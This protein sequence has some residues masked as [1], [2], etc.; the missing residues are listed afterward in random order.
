MTATSVSRLARVPYRNIGDPE[1]LYELCD[2]V[3]AVGRDLSLPAV[4]RRIVQ[5]A[6]RL[7]DA[8][9]GALGVLDRSGTRLEQFL[10]IGVD[11]DTVRAIGRLPEGHGILG[12]LIVDPKPLRLA[13]LTEHRDS[14]GFPD[15]HPLMRSFLG[16]PIKSR[17]EVFGN[18]YLTEKIGADEFSAE[19][20]ELVEWLAA[21]AGIAIANAR[22]HGRLR[23]FTL[24]EDRDRIAR[25]LHDTVIQRLFA[26]GLQLEQAATLDVSQLP[27]RVHHAVEDI[28]DTIRQIRTTIFALEHTAPAAG[29]RQRVFAVVR[30]MEA[31]LGCPVRVRFE[32]PVDT[33]V[34]DPFAEHLI[35]VLREALTNAAKHARADHVDVLVR[36][37][38]ELELEVVDDG[39]G[40]RDAAGRDGHGLRNMAARAG[41]LGGGSTIAPRPGGG[42][43]VRWHVPLPAVDAPGGAG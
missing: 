5:S 26:I 17:G 3:L 28:D 19:D 6:C 31:I 37:G 21:A 42:T 1:R 13:D 40:L 15:H 4:L 7:A 16:V 14:Y 23:D 34:P 29:T 35:A 36:A 12:R 33:V 43:A 10:H 8:R 32:G 41:S 25:D 24:L 22:A 11:E 39:I 9:Y 38:E 2:A 27:D 30:E 18:L 20:E